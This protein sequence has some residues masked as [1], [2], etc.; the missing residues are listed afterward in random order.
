MSLYFLGDNLRK[1]INNLEIVN[2][3]SNITGSRVKAA[4]FLVLHWNNSEII[5]NS[6][7]AVTMPACELYFDF[8]KRTNVCRYEITPVSIFYNSLVMGNAKN[9][10]P[11]FNTL[12][13]VHISSI[14]SVYEIYNKHIYASQIDNLTLQFGSDNEKELIEKKEE[15]YNEIACEWLKHHSEVWSRHKNNTDSTWISFKQSDKKI[16]IGAL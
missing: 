13:K 7:V 8:K 2:K 1:V 15:Y 11:L 10:T 14:Q 12:G 5:D 9:P 16:I 6:Y 3:S 4:K